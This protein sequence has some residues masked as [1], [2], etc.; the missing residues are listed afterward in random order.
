[1]Y[2]C[3]ICVNIYMCVCVCIPIYIGLTQTAVS[4]AKHAYQHKHTRSELI[5]DF[6]EKIPPV[7][8]VRADGRVSEWHSQLCI[9]L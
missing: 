6:G 2:M 5:H 3:N 4:S 1:M 9:A 8:Y 7:S